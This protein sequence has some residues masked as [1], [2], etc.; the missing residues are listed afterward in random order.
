MHELKKIFFKKKILIYGL[1][2]TGISTF[3][4]L[5]KT[6]FV[7]VYD[8]VVEKTKIKKFKNHNVNKIQIL[9]TTFDYIVIS[10]GINYKRCGLKRFWRKNKNKN[11]TYED[12]L[13]AKTDK[14][15]LAKL[16]NRSL[17]I[18][19][20]M[21]ELDEFD[22]GPRNVFNFGH[23]FGH[24]LESATDDAVPHGVAVAYGM[25]L[26][27]LIS[28]RLGLIDIELR[29]SITPLLQSIWKDITIPD[30]EIDR[31]FSALS[32]DTKNIG[33]EVKVILTRG[34]G[35]M[36]KTT[37]PMTNEVKTLINNFFKD[38]LYYEQAW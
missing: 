19:A 11:Y 27:N 29:N 10:P 5:R 32:K 13:K 20:P 8:D 35:D 21:F 6:N 1:S 17:S 23:S 34:L 2:L 9:K 30:F 25:D 16:V 31:Y 28:A 33:N 15:T 3:D 4:Y 37:L 22:K 18:K 14:Q 36:F 38:K 26:A 7:S 24:A 12:I